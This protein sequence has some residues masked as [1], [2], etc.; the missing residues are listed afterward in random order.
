MW[1]GFSSGVFT[2][3]LTQ[4]LWQMTPA[5]SLHVVLSNVLNTLEQ[6]AFPAQEMGLEKQLA[7]HIEGQNP[8]Q[9]TIPMYFSNGDL[10][11][12]HQAKAD[13]QS[14]EFRRF[15]FGRK[16]GRLESRVQTH[17]PESI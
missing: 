10:I 12:S 5:T 2:Y 6:K 11:T 15:S 7:A 16:S 4:Q 1:Q 14:A 13:L 8:Q 17:D 3:A 9:E